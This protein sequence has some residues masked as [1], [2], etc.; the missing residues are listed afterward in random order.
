MKLET[1]DTGQ[2]YRKLVNMK[3]ENTVLY[4]MANRTHIWLDNA[5]ISKVICVVGPESDEKAIDQFDVAR[6]NILVC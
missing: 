2:Y 3:L 5:P 1:N 6:K 4:L